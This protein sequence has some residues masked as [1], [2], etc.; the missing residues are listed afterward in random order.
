MQP[1]H[2]HHESHEHAEHVPVHGDS[3]DYGHNPA[4]GH[5]HDHTH[6]CFEWVH[7]VL[8]F[9]HRH[10]HGEASA[11]AVLETSARGIWALK[12]SLLGLGATAVFQLAIVLLSGSVG[13]L[14]DTIHNCSDALTAVPLWIAFVLGRRAAS[15]RYTYGYGR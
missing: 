14:S 12:V 3:H 5:D 15:R 1:Q 2:E 8:P 4:H 13:L 9:G 6:G 7:E 11:D 10:S